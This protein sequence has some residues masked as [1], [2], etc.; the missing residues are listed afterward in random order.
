MKKLFL[1]SFTLLLILPL[2]LKAQVK[3]EKS[4]VKK[5]DD[6]KLEFHYSDEAL[7]QQVKADKA[8][9]D[10]NYEANSFAAFNPQWNL[11]NV[12][13]DK[14]ALKS[15]ATDYSNLLSEA[16]TSFTTDLVYFE[17]GQKAL[18]AKSGNKLK[19]LFFGNIAN[20]N[21]NINLY[22]KVSECLECSK[23]VRYHR[24]I[25]GNTMTIRMRAEDD[26]LSDVFYLLTFNK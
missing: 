23:V 1:S 17:N 9:S 21:N 11:V 6:Y 22:H 18:F 16:K 20:V 2:M 26:N 25:N 8:A 12:D 19:P 5:N 14:K 7:Q 15:N 13:I 10:R 24:I 4:H 3:S